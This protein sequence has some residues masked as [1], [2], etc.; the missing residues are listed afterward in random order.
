MPDQS[1]SCCLR[2]LVAA[3]LISS[4][5]GAAAQL[6]YWDLRQA[7]SATSAQINLGGHVVD[8][9]TLRVASDVSRRVLE[10]GRIEATVLVVTGT[11]DL[12]AFATET[13]AGKFIGITL[14][15][16]DLTMHD[17]DALASVIGH[18][19][20]HLKAD[21]FASS[22]RSRA[23]SKFV[24]GALAVIAGAALGYYGVRDIGSL[25]TAVD[26]VK[27]LNV[28][29]D[30]S[31]SREQEREADQLASQLSH[32]AG[33]N[34]WGGVRLW[35]LME[36]ASG[37]TE[38]KWRSTHPG[39]RERMNLLEQAAASISGSG[40]SKPYEVTSVYQT[41]FSQKKLP[42]SEVRRIASTG[43][44]EAISRIS[45]DYLLGGL[46]LI[47]AS[48]EPLSS[49]DG[50]PALANALPSESVA[51]LERNQIWWH[52]GVKVQDRTQVFLL[53]NNPL[54]VPVETLALES[55]V[56]DCSAPSS[57]SSRYLVRLSKA[58]P[59]ERAA[60]ITLGLEVPS[61]DSCL[62]IVAAG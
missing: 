8:A 39:S 21:H 59:S 23:V 53:L 55:F 38:T 9:G 47:A 16:L 24:S 36:S 46:P 25:S 43:R 28:G 34:A 37:S 56:G 50:P 60:V 44:A 51:E 14:S 13:E 20:G 58:I 2:A 27:D 4:C 10:A 49:K 6:K 19:V 40:E 22:R 5:A 11:D 42:M 12:N 45:Y 33:F 62:N 54:L 15:L 18:E 29:Y 26:I 31:F 30:A 61:G 17:P 3:I 57:V 41:G 35:S 32:A 48:S 7:A 1:I 52:H